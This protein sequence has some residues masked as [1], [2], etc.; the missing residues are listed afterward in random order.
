MPR[1]ESA[2]GQESASSQGE[3]GE[4]GEG[5][6]TSSAKTVGDNL[7]PSGDGMDTFR[8]DVLGYYHAAVGLGRTLFP[9]FAMALGM[10]EGW[11]DGKVRA[12]GLYTLRTLAI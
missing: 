2:P 10:E 3:G 6:T 8:Q 7:W 11:F 4:G 12:F 9:L 1:Q 5:A